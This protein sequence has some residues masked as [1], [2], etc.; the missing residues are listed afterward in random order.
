MALESF[1]HRQSGKA[2]DGKGISGQASAQ[3]LRQLFCNHLPAGDS[4]KAGDM[5]ALDG[6]I[7]RSNM[8]SKL[9]LARVA[10]EKAIEVNIS[11]AE[12]GSVVPWFQPPD[13]NF[14]LRVTHG[15][16]F[17]EL[18]LVGLPG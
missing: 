2:E 13:A 11:T 16:T 5:A 10:L 17:S 14:K 1:V 4:D 12:F 3:V 7:G 18:R 6:D 9:I 15:T 8:V